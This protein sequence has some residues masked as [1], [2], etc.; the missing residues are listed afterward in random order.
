MLGKE[1][2]IL[3]VVIHLTRTLRN[4][5]KEKSTTYLIVQMDRMPPALKY[6][7]RNWW[8]KWRKNPECSLHQSEDGP[9]TIFQKKISCNWQASC[10]P[11][12]WALAS[13][14]FGKSGNVNFF[15]TF[16]LTT[17]QN[18]LLLNVF[19]YFFRRTKNSAGWLGRTLNMSSMALLIVTV[20]NW[21]RS[22]G[23]REVSQARFWSQGSFI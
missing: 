3:P 18:F 14:I 4:P 6:T 1:E 8:M 13:T 19:V 20:H 7:D 23:Q 11:V 16:S 5:G 15:F 2:D 21:F 10:K 12:A 22:S 9:D 17:H